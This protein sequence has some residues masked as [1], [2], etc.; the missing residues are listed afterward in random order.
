MEDNSKPIGGMS[1]KQVREFA[2]RATGAQEAINAAG[3]G[4]PQ[5]VEYKGSQLPLATVTQV[6]DAVLDW[7]RAP[8][9]KDAVQ[10]DRLVSAAEALDAAL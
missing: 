8:F 2:R 1:E 4:R 9:G 6:L 3:L 10:V 5:T 7:Q